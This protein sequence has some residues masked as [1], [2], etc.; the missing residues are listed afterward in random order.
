MKQVILLIMPLLLLGGCSGDTEPASGQEGYRPEGA[1]PLQVDNTVLEASVATRVDPPKLE[2]NNAQ[3]G[4]CCAVATGY[5]NTQTNIPYKYSTAAP[6]GWAP[7][8]AAN[9]VWLLAGDVNVCAYYPY[10]ASYTNSAAIP[11]ATA[12][13]NTAGDICFDGNR[14][15]NGTPSYKS[16]TFNMIR[17][18]AKIKFNLKK[19]DYPGTC[20]V[21][22]ITLSNANLPKAGTINITSTTN[23]AVTTT[24]G[25]FEYTP[26][27]TGNMTVVAAGEDTQEVL[28]VPFTLSGEFVVTLA[29]DGKNMQLKLPAATFTNSKI[30]PGKFY[31]LTM[32]LNGTE[33]VVTS[34]TIEDWVDVPLSDSGSDFKPFPSS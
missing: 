30:E 29:V 11:L 23:Q 14:A 15:M 5:T 34:V 25:N 27:S 17:A 19:G 18:M 22:K 3:I 10:N 20:A 13:Y 24:K 12:V 9:P 16:T 2:T 6:A 4:I 26:K 33:L 1:V 28:L 7:S 21:S 31:Q 8:N 32:K